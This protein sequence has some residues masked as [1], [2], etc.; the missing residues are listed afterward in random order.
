MMRQLFGFKV[1][2]ML[3]LDVRPPFAALFIEVDATVARSIVD[4][5]FCIRPLLSGCGEPQI[6]D[7]IIGAVTIYVVYFFVWKFS[8]MEKP[9]QSVGKMLLATKFY[10]NISARV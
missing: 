8:I 2:K 9:C 6:Y 1:P 7:T 4:I 3:A 5:Y 10:T